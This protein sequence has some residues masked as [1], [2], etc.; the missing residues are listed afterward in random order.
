V[1]RIDKVT[2][3]DLRRVA[4]LVFVESNRTVGMLESTQL[5][6]GAAAPESR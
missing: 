6:Q 1:E 3:E 5:A 2:K 4:N